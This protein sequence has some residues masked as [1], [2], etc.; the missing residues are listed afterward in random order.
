M[1]RKIQCFGIKE[2]FN[3]NLKQTL[4]QTYIFSCTASVKGRQNMK[5]NIGIASV[6]PR[7]SSRRLSVTSVLEDSAKIY[8]ASWI[9]AR[10]SS[11]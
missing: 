4:I 5:N 8:W 7:V 10:I 3:R 9:L 1:V 2:E 6:G 11:I